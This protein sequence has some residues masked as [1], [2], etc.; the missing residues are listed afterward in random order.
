MKMGNDFLFLHLYNEVVVW[1]LVSG[2]FVATA[3]IA[4]NLFV[5]MLI[6]L[7]TGCKM[8]L[9]F[10]FLLSKTTSTTN[11]NENWQR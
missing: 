6:F 3:T 1:L 4:R 9:L 11:D 2:G 7:K 5:Y 10:D 8:L